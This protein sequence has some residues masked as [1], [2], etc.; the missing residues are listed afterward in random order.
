MRQ[1]L[2]VPVFTYVL[3]SF[4]CQ[5]SA[6]NSAKKPEAAAN[7]GDTAWQGSPPPSP[8]PVHGSDSAS[9]SVPSPPSVGPGE[10]KPLEPPPIEGVLALTIASQGVLLVSQKKQLKAIASYQEPAV[11][12]EAPARWS[13]MSNEADASLTADGIIVARKPGK[14]MVKAKFAGHV[15]VA[16]LE[17]ILAMLNFKEEQFWVYRFAK[18]KLSFNS[19]WDKEAGS[20]IERSAQ[21]LPPMATDCL[22]QA[23]ERFAELQNQAEIK[24]RLAA[25]LAHGSTSQLIFLI[26]VVAVDGRRNELR[27]LDRDA[28]FWH[29]TREDL[30]PSLAVSKFQEGA[31][32]WEAIVSP[33]ACVQPDATEMMRFLDYA[34]SRLMTA[35]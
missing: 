22:Q 13:L 2:I 18:E 19:P 12:R 9:P 33:A 4:S 1:L 25:A 10:P 16:E 35:P 31:W 20:A 34:T 11:S 15:A 32:V 6:S 17:F 23:K 3:F 21:N 29:W 5:K 26:N 28:Y 24:N 14:V 27:R 7:G 8:L 30:R